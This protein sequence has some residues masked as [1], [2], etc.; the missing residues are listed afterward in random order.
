MT[1]EQKKAL[2]IINLMI[3]EFGLEVIIENNVVIPKP[4]KQ[5]EEI[6]QDF[7]II[8]DSNIL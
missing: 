7:R 5:D 1:L 8:T 2:A 4:P 3:T 6:K